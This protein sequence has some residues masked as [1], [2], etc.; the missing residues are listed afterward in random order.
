[1]TE[2]LV[3][4][5]TKEISESDY[6]TPEQEQRLDAREK[7]V[8]SF[9]NMALENARFAGDELNAIKSEGDWKKLRRNSDFPAYSDWGE[10]AKARFGKGKTMSYNY[11]HISYI[12]KVIEEEGF[13]PL[14]LGSIQNAMAVYFELRKLGYYGKKEL[15]PLFRTVLSKGMHIVENI[16]PID[17]SGEVKPT[18]DS[19]QAAF[20]TIQEIVVNQSY[21]IEGHQVPLTLGQIAVDDQAS[22]IMYE[23]VQRRRLAAAEEVEDKKKARFTPK[24]IDI[25]A[26]EVDS[27]KKEIYMDCP[28]H[29]SQ[30]GESLVQAG[31]KMSCGCFGISELTP[32]G[33]KLV[34]YE[35]EQL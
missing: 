22:Q 15:H 4:T 14:E 1:M 10:Y 35:T 28:I 6:L 34:H 11:M 18:P 31:I 21:E 25:E 16:S 33:H 17:D 29:G 26:K 30:R 12:M 20:Q 32:T 3:I 23:Q 2:A 19:I 9:S 8:I 27:K 5:E 13:D 24:I 7:K